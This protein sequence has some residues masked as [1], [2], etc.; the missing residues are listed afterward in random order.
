MSIFHVGRIY[1]NEK[2]IQFD[3]DVCVVVIGISRR[4]FLFSDLTFE[5]SERAVFYKYDRFP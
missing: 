4:R 3:H 5:Q 1:R 2:K